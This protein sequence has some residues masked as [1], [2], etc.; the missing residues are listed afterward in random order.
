MISIVG[1]IK[2]DETKP[3]R[4]KYL[5]ACIRSYGFLKDHCQFILNLESPS[6]QLW[7]IV[8]QEILQYSNKVYCKTRNQPYGKTYVDLLK[9]C[10][11]DTVINFME[12]HFMVCDDIEYIEHIQRTMRVWQVDVC[13]SSFWDVE[14]NSCD[15]LDWLSS[16]NH[17]ELIFVNNL[18]NFT[19]YQRYYKSRFYI[20][21]N[22]ITTREFANRFWNR[23]LGQRP[24]RHE[25]GRFD[26]KWIHVA[27][28]PGFELQAAIDDDHGEP[29]TCLLK[30]SNC[31][32]WNEI[33]GQVK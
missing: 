32:K 2:V 13:K 14:Q 19:A 6:D 15:K 12:D 4:I 5:I 11:Y 29:G 30:R 31:E 20:G 1:N 27:M 22:F 9:L 8:G 10:K 33:W 23:D 28:I 17:G 16:D 21:C 3:E 26:P 18:T 24:H 25:I 7:K